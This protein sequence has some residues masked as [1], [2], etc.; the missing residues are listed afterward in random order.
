[1]YFAVVQYNS[2]YLVTFH[3]WTWAGLGE[4]AGWVEEEMSSSEAVTV[5]YAHVCVIYAAVE[6]TQ[7]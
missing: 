7:I 1:M 6:V 4:V 3:I 5:R 2:I